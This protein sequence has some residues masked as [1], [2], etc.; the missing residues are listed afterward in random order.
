MT[1]HA[2]IAHLSDKTCRKQDIYLYASGGHPCIA[3]AP[4]VECM[5]TRVPADG[6]AGLALLLLLSRDVFPLCWL[7]HN[8]KTKLTVDVQKVGGG[9]GGD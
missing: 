3:D 1:K 9:G 6:D 4:L 7:V 2:G 5:C 8:S